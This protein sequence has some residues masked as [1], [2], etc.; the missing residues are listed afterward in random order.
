M[1]LIWYFFGR[2][3]R[4]VTCINRRGR[5]KRKFSQTN[6]ER[7]FSQI[8]SESLRNLKYKP[9]FCQKSSASWR[10]PS[11]AMVYENISDLMATIGAAFYLHW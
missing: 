7:K 6:T 3:L 11:A 5:Y 9:N 8:N 10:V 4:W 2:G 1:T